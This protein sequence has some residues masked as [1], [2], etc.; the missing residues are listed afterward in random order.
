MTH[1][2]VVVALLFASVVVGACAGKK[3]PKAEAAAAPKSVLEAEV[4]ANSL[5][6]RESPSTSAA[7]VGSVKRGDHVLAPEAEAEGWLYIESDAGQKGYVS[8]KYVRI[9]EGKPAESPA[10]APAAA[11]P[12]AAPAPA[13]AK[14]KAEPAARKPPA[15]SKLARI[16]EGM[17]EAEVVSILG[18]PTSRQ[19]YVTGKAWI[20]F[21]YGSD[22]SRLDYRYKGVGLIVFSRNR[23]SSKTHVVRVDSDPNEDGYP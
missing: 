16:T 14:A 22:A 17:S 23:Y 18:E 1:R 9:L 3:A 15:G 11:A 6:I 7:V 4:T 2:K 10:R 13:A 5:N 12:A 21:Y 19:D 20:P 8:A